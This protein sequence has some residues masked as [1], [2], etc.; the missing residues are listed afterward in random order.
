MVVMIAVMRSNCF[1]MDCLGRESESTKGWVMFSL[2][3]TPLHAM[4]P[5]QCT[6]TRPNNLYTTYK[7]ALY[8]ALHNLISIPKF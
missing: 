5:L 3:I 8:T 2:S 1:Y 7:V 6:T 4:Y